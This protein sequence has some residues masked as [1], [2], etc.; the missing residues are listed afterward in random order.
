VPRVSLT[1]DGLARLLDRLDPDR[2]HAAAEYE[3]LRRTLI[4]FFSWRGALE[5]DFCADEAIDRL[6]RRLEEGVIVD[7]LG[8]YVRAI[9]RMVMLERQRVPVSTPIEAVDPPGGAVPDE[10]DDGV[11]E[12]LEGC[13]AVLPAEGRSLVLAYYEGERGSKIA[14]RRRLARSLGL[15]DA[16]LRSRVQRIR[17]R[18]EDCMR[19]CLSRRETRQ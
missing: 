17:D 11:V 5:P 9:A 10:S 6:A 16:A 8:T 7:D 2:D 13:L 14:N 12:C 1:P 4:R 15:T 19:L 18:L 3:R